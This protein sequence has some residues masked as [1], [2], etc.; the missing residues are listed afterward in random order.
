[1][2]IGLGA[3]RSAL[4]S[5]PRALWPSFSKTLRRTDHELQK[6]C[7]ATIVDISNPM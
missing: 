6:A 2:L 3:H 5:S 1:M 4:D 7:G